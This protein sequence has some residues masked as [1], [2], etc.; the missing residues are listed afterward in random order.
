MH[1][2]DAVFFSH[3][4]TMASVGLTQGSVSYCGEVQVGSLIQSASGILTQ[5][6]PRMVT[7]DTTGQEIYMN[8]AQESKLP[9]YKNT[10][11]KKNIHSFTHSFVF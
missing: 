10:L 1:G 9:L 6:A 2:H 8:H 11:S 5:R 3:I 7:V 4:V